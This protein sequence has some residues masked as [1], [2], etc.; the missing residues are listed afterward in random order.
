MLSTISISDMAIPLSL[1]FAEQLDDAVHDGVGAGRTTG[2][3]HVHRDDLVEA[4]QDIIRPAI[5]AA[6]HGAGA[7]GDDELRVGR[8]LVDADDA[9]LDLTGHGTGGDDDVGVARRGLE[10]DPEALDVEARRQRRD[11]LDVAGIAGARVEVQDPGRL[12]PG[13]AGELVE[14]VNSL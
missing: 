11:D 10:Q 2:N 14:H 13:P 12:D 6:G 7:D 3:I 5:N 8:L 4:T 1:E 9:V